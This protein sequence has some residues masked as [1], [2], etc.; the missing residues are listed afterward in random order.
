MDQATDTPGMG[1]LK[2]TLFL[3]LL[4]QLEIKTSISSWV[5]RVLQRMQ[6]PMTF[7]KIYTTTT[8]RKTTES[9]T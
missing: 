3:F 5:Q 4:Y 1:V 8:K 7:L 2:P 6:A 9:I